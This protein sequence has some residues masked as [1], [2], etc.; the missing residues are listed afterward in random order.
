MYI[1]DSHEFQKTYLNQRAVDLDE[2]IENHDKQ[3]DIIINAM[4][5]YKNEKEDL[6][7]EVYNCIFL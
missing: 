4:N 3:L 5:V 2:V 1:I 7:D 6:S